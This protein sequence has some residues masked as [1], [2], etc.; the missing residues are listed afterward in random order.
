MISLRY[1]TTVDMRRPYDLS[2]LH[3]TT[4]DMRRPYD[5]SLLHHYSGYEKA[6]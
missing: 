2:L 6:S 1:T 3:I 4:V 5:L